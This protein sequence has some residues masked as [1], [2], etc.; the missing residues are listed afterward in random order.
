MN[1]YNLNTIVLG[2]LCALIFR[3][4]VI[5]YNTYINTNT[6]DENVLK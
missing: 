2:S 4:Q 3:K 6:T 5:F 1:K